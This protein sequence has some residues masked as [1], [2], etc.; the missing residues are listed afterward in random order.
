[1]T[2]GVQEVTILNVRLQNLSRQEL[3]QRLTD[4]LMINPN[5]DV[6]MK[7]QHDRE[8]L[9]A[10]QTAEFCICDSQIVK[11]ASNFLGTPIREKIS[12]SDFFGEFCAY[13]VG[14]P[15]IRVFLLGAAE[16][17]AERARCNVNQ[18]VGRDIITHAHSPSFGFERNEDESRRIVELINASGCTV[19][20]I[21][22]GCPKQEKWVARHRSQ[23]HG[24]RIILCI[25]ATID[26]EAGTVPRAPAWMSRVG[27]EW[28]FRMVS[29][30]KRLVRRYMVDDLPFFWL[31][32][33]QRLGFY[34]P[35][36]V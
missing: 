21:G 7:L 15:G 2:E 10:V 18:R 28:V 29:D 24:I 22:V 33:K 19:L 30:P 35:P 1:M 32:L 20:A 13:H 9:R 11:Y 36:S 3:L 8:F 17:V 6:I 23:L 16:G 25:G 31:L 12:G 27:L 34:N 14:N 26:F 5:V 4:G